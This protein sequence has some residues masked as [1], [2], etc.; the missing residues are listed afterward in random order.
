MLHSQQMISLPAWGQ[1]QAHHHAWLPPH[2]TPPTAGK[3]R[4]IA[5]PSAPGAARTARDFTSSALREWNLAE[6]AQD[7]ELIAS[8]L[9]TNAIRHGVPLGADVR[10]HP[11]VEL[12]WSPQSSQLIC[13]VTDWN[14]Q[15]PLLMPVGPCAE[16]GRGLHIVDALAT[17]WGWTTL[18]PSRKTVWAALH[19]PAPAT[20]SI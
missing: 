11:P 18:S 1:C 6:L 15:P 20:P 13:A 2:L 8:E 9:V 12:G 17:T 7:A 4:R 5:L 16:A 19:L 3:A 14:T 10:E